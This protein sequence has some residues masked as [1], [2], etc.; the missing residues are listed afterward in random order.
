M[1]YLGRSLDVTTP[2]PWPQLPADK[3]IRFT[4]EVAGMIGITAKT[5]H[6]IALIGPDR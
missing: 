1:D 5:N 2:V 3:F 6:R 4:N